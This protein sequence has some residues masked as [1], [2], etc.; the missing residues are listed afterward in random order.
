NFFSIACSSRSIN[1]LTEPAKDPRAPPKKRARKTDFLRF[2]NAQCRQAGH[3]RNPDFVR[4]RARGRIEITFE[5]AA[6]NVRHRSALHRA[7]GRGRDRNQV[8]TA[9]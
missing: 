7:G 6:D 8:D 5:T 3:L 1:E 2:P 9:A 4:A